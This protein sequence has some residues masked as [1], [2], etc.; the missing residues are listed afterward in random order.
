MRVTW[1]TGGRPGG[2]VRSAFWFAV[3]LAG[4]PFSAS[5]G[6][7]N[8][9]QGPAAA[10]PPAAKSALAPKTEVPWGELR[11]FEGHADAVLG[12]AFTPDGKRFVSVGGDA[13]SADGK[14]T[15]SG[16]DWAVRV[17]DVETGRELWRLAGHERDVRAVAVAPDGRTV[18]TGSSDKTL[19]AWDLVAC[20]ALGIVPGHSAWV[21]SVCFSK[22]GTRALLGS[23]DFNPIVLWDVAKAQMIRRWGE[24]LFPVCCVAL[25]PNGR[26]AL[27][28]HG[29]GLVRLWVTENGREVRQFQGH[30]GA[31]FCVTYTPDGSQAISGGEDGTLRLWDVA[32]GKEVGRLASHQG[33]VRMVAL[34]PDGRRA[35]SGGDDGLVIVSSVREP[36]VLASFEGHAGAVR[37][38]AI[39]PDGRRAVSGGFDK[40]VRLWDLTAVPA[41]ADVPKGQRLAVLDF[42]NRGPA[43]EI[44]PSARRWPRCS[45]ATFRPTR[46][47]ASWSAPGCNNS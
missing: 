29:D 6:Q 32:T 21:Q 20:R 2:S 1:G 31:V 16:G 37:T 23:W 30:T 40:I 34:T 38:L 26:Q 25:A 36:R 10:T 19:R 28:A 22:D 33:P 47:S 13:S 43:V 39:S 46:G 8:V 14:A 5:H 11:R 44:G 35:V 17:W 45:P 3:L 7:G 12:V 15:P 42:A 4:A 41:E 9:G 27:S 24:K 18:Y